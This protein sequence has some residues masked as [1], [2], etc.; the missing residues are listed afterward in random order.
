[1]R[2]LEK[3]V[4]PV[5]NKRDLAEPPLEYKSE[6]SKFDED[7]SEEKEPAQ[8]LQRFTNQLEMGLNIKKKI[9]PY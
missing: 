6:V 1:M 5:L 8:E 4:V 9:P 7:D 2:D 3:E